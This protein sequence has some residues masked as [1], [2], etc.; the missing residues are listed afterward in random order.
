MPQRPVQQQP[1]LQQPMPQ[2]PMPQRPVPQQPKNGK[3]S[4]LWLWIVIAVVLL[5]AIGAGT[6]Y[7]LGYSEK[8]HTAVVFDDEEE[9]NADEDDDSANR[10]QRQ[11][12]RRRS[13]EQ[14][15]NAGSEN[16]DADSSSAAVDM[17]RYDMACTRELTESDLAGLSA[18]ELKVMR[19]WIFARHGYKFRT[20]E[21]RAYFSQQPWYEPLYD[22]VSGMLT[23][24]ELRN[25]DFIKS[26]E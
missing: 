26:H 6:W 20:D 12:H 13:S 15:V 17:E 16:P 19:N 2:Q 11:R 14:P 1:N 22:D 18:E 9:V 10:R 23:D 5:G 21:M 4:L 24:I 3:S 8:P 7:L 25:I